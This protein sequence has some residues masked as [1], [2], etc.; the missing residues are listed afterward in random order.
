[1][2]VIPLACDSL[3][4]RSMA[5]Y[6]ETSDLKVVI[7]PAVSLAAIKSELPPHPIE[8]TREAEHWEIIKRSAKQ[9]DVLIVTHYHYDHHNPSEP[10]VYQDK[11][12]FVKHPQENIN[13]S[14]RERAAYFLNV[15]GGIPSQIE[16]SDGKAFAFGKTIIKFSPA[17][18]H[19]NNTRLGYVTEVSITD[20]EY[21]LVH[22][23][24]IEGGNLDCQR[25]FILQENPDILIFDGPMT[26][27][28]QNIIPNMLRIIKETRV[29]DFL[30]EHH[31]LRKLKWQ[32]K[33][34]EAINTASELNK[35]VICAA[36]FSGYL[37]DQLEAKRKQLYEQFPV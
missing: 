10:E 23:S 22:T 19:G 13:E 15:L 1:M 12:I 16:Y 28:F 20:G 24:D 18:P 26:Y 4:T 5:T 37:Q 2:K 27:P 29:K 3:G 6:I 7:D 25:D 8:L 21:K 14:Q 35:R 34:K 17:V 9:A 33:I 31:Y 30:I 32:D 36:E 11:K